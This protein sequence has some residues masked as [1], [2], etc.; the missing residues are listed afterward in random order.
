MFWKLERQGFV[1][2]TLYSGPVIVLVQGIEEQR[3]IGVHH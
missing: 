1:D 3:G 2:K